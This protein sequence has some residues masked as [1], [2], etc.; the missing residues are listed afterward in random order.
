MSRFESKIVI[1]TGGGSGIGADAARRFAAEGASVAVADLNLEG[2]RKVVE[3]IRAAGGRAVAFGTDVVSEEQTVELIEGTVEAFGGLDIM[4][5]N[6]GIGEQPT[7]IDERPLED[8]QKVIDV[9]L[10]GAFLGTKHAA[11]A[12]K[13]LERKGVIVNIASILGL[14]G[15]K[16]APAY[17]AAKHGLL[18]FTKSVALE[19]AEFG[20]RCVGVSPAFIRT[21]LIEGMEEAVLPLHPMGR[22]GEPKDVSDLILFLASDEAAFLTGATYLVDGGYT[23]Q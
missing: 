5:N 1:M 17:T 19:L 15:F 3:E 14:V 13:A 16:G 2:A 23:S 12:F 22:L 11:R 10:T 9:N 6:A 20:I 4:V 8:W 7:P 21:P 18:G